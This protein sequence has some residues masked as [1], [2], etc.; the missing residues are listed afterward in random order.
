VRQLISGSGD[1][2][3]FARGV[4]DGRG[5]G[6]GFARDDLV[7]LLGDHTVDSAGGIAG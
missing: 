1:P 7:T 5:L 3:P 2:Q 6:V 4:I